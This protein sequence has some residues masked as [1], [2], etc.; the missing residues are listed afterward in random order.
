MARFPQG[1][2][3]SCEI[4]WGDDDSFLEDIFRRQVQFALKHGF[5]NLYIFGTAGEGYAVDTSRFQ[6]IVRV[7][8]S[9][10]AR[11]DVYPQVGVIDL[12]TE[13]IVEK[14]RYAHESGFRI[15]QISLPCWGALNETE[16]LTFFKDVCGSFPDSKFLHYNLGRTRRFLTADDYRRITF[17]VPN[18]VATKNTLAT[19]MET[20]SLVRK[21]PELQHFLSEALLPLGF[22][23]GECSLLSSFAWVFPT[24]TK[25]LFEY[26]RAHQFDKF[27]PLLK[28][29]LEAVEDV[30]SP[31]RGHQRMDGAYDKLIKRL[32]GLDMPLR[33][34]SPY[35]SFSEEIFQE[36]YQI[37]HRKYADWKF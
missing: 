20:P 19:A 1:I 33:L 37:L 25:E 29:Y 4:P 6:Q 28:D 21:V 2:L 10:T 24:K 11:E 3:V 27:L 32:G 16:L 5:R 7:F 26:G 13:R 35:Q 14:L 8:Y 17:E 34:L 23:Y 22:L 9:E 31:T 15:F 18:L 36:C 30:L 12:S